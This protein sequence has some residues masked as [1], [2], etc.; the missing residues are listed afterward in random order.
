MMT[1]LQGTGAGGGI[2]IGPL[3]FIRQQT[4]NEAPRP[5]ENPRAE[6][7]RFEQARQHAIAQLREITASMAGKIGHENAQIFEIHQMMLQD[8]DYITQVSKIITAQR[9]CAE[10]AVSQT[11]YTLADV[12]ATMPDEYLSARAADV[13]DI[14]RRVLGILKGI[15]PTDISKWRPCVLAA[16]NF[17]PSQTIYFCEG[18][19]LALLAKR[20][21]ANSHAAIVARALNIPAVCEIG[22]ALQGA[23]NG[24]TVIVQGTSGQI[25]IEPDAPTL[26]MYRTKQAQQAA[27]G[28]RR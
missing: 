9:Q 13:Q 19:I 17:T 3:R 27:Q 15:K 22:E 10:Y 1:Y 4:L 24:Q 28:P 11:C 6:L 21:S 8:S 25:I 18:N 23:Q 14:S 20:G 16:E 26:Q 5:I 7:Q 2:A 12:F